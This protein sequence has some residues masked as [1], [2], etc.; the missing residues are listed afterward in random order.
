MKSFIVSMIFLSAT[1]LFIAVNCVYV[2]SVLKKT[3]D[4]LLELPLIS[5]S[6]DIPDST[7]DKTQQL[8]EFWQKHQRFLSF[9]I[10]TAEL[11]DCSVAIGNLAAFCSSDTIADYDAALTESRLRIHTLLSRERFTLKNIL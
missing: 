1:V 7:R 4:I 9:T 5:E 3:E 11:R 6:G 2:T 8:Y 10:N